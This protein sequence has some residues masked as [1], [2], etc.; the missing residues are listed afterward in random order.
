MMMKFIKCRYKFLKKLNKPENENK[1]LDSDK[2]YDEKYT[3][4]HLMKK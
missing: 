1:V 2:Y 4:W 3:P